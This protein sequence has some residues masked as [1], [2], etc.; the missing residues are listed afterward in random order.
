[1]LPG[2][3]GMMVAQLK[4]AVEES[5]DNQARILRDLRQRLFE[6]SKREV[7][8]RSGKEALV[9]LQEAMLD[10]IAGR[11]PVRLTAP[12][13]TALRNE[14]YIDTW[15]ELVN[16]NGANVTRSPSGEVVVFPPEKIAELKA[17]PQIK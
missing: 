3:K 15:A 6:A 2:A 9:K 16:S 13:A 12:D 4:N 5:A 8:R 7:I 17:N 1:M 10:E 11:T 14:F